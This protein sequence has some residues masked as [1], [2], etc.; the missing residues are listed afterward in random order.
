MINRQIGRSTQSQQ[1]PGA[2][3]ARQLIQVKEISGFKII[4]MVF[5]AK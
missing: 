2:L 4:F 5:K 1:Q 3:S